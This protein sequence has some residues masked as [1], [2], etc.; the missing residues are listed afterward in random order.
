MYLQSRNASDSSDH[1]VK[2]ADPLGCLGCGVPTGRKNPRRRKIVKIPDSYDSYDKW[3][4]GFKPSLHISSKD[5]KHRLEN[6]FLKL[7]SYGMVSIW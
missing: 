5:R 6:M 4:P 1:I 3:E 2:I 7:S